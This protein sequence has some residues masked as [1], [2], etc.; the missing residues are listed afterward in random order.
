MKRAPAVALLMIAGALAIGYWAGKRHAAGVSALPAQTAE[1]AAPATRKL[2]YYRNPMGLSDTSPVPKKDAMGM[3]YL[4][5]YA[6]GEADDPGVVKVSPERVQTLGVKTAL[7]EE[8]ILEAGVRAVGRVEINERA[9][10]D[11]APRFDGWIER[12]YVNA[13][14]DP[15]RKGQALFSVYS[16]E[17]VSTYK[18]LGIARELQ[19]RT[20]EGDPGARERAERLAGASQERLKNWGIA[21]GASQTDTSHVV[22]SSPATGI[23]LD[24]PAVAG[25]RFMAGTAIYRIVD[26]STVWVIADVY[27]QD[28][29]RVKT[30]QTA[31]I[32]IDAFP[33]R[34]FSA[35]VSYLYPTLNAATRTTQ[36]RMALSNGDRQLRPGMFAHVEI[37]TGGALPRLV[38]PASA[39]IDTGSRQIVL[40]A[41]DAGRFKPQPVK[42]GLRS[43]DFVE[44]LDGL[45]AGDRVVVAASFL[46]DAESNL[47]EALGNF[48]APGAGQT[49]QPA[50]VFH[51]VGTLDSIDAKAN[52][53]TITHEPIRALKWPGMTMDF[54]LASADVAKGLV[55]GTPIRFDFEQRGPGE[56]VITHIEANSGAESPAHG[57]H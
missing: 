24:K 20:R 26:L 45:K 5:V 7:A 27:E 17:L 54:D 6:G 42:V 3:D 9:I 21:T 46:I 53:V 12:L 22:F 38:V 31:M 13:T 28:L 32:G 14:G 19:Q 10:Y 29:D 50:N 18:E 52:S 25:M 1:P 55:P 34:H 23:V 47:K 11:V 16:P 2:L 30:G 39:L 37:A 41:L 57:T 56:F 43:G 36:V 44:I 33:D 8:K 35:K 48:T 51:A 15:V 40:I 4:P 49:A